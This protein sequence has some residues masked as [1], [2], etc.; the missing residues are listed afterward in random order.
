MKDWQRLWPRYW[1]QNQRTDWE[2]DA[3]LNRLLDEYPVTFATYESE[4]TAKV[5]PVEV[6]TG[7][8]PYAYGSAYRPNAGDGLPSVAT[9]KR[10]KGLVPK[11][12]R[13]REVKAL[14]K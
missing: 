10:L 5:G 14:L 1:L 3:I 11:V 12:D 2:W 4:L 6:W 7:N 13:L 9:R 8:F